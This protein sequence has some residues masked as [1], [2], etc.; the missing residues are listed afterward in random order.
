MQCNARAAQTGSS[1]DEHPK[2]MAAAQTVNPRTDVPSKVPSL[3]L[4]QHPTFEIG[5]F[6]VKYH[7]LIGAW[8][9][10]PSIGSLILV[11]CVAPVCIV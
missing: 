8:F 9:L 6:N 4:R 3:V 2:K 7:Q 1:C 5:T 10:W 11:D